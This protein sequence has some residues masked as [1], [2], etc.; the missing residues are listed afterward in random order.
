MR[1]KL[2]VVTVTYKPDVG[3]LR[4]FFESYRRFNDLGD[5]SKLIVVD[6]SPSGAWDIDSMEAEFAEVDFVRN[7]S[8]P[9]FGAS[10]NR[11]YDQYE[12]DYVLFINNDV[13][14]LEPLFKALIGEFD[15]DDRIGCIGIHQDGGAPSFFPKMT[16]PKG[17][18]VDIF[19]DRV[20][21][22]SGAFMLFRSDIFKEIGMFDENMFMYFEEFDLSERLIAKGYKTVFLPE[23]KFLHKAGGRG[24]GNEFASMKGTQTLHYICRKYHLRYDLAMSKGFL[25]RQCKLIVYNILTLHFKEV[26]KLVRIMCYRIH[27]VWTHRNK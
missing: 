18:K 16:A 25:F 20:H 9:G 11:G 3:E 26:P 1:Y 10:N 21:F 8:N 12:S 24:T 23:Y 5:D 6:N 13:E 2:T 17:T 14:L 27:Y 7:P 15:K 22:I 4:L 19:D